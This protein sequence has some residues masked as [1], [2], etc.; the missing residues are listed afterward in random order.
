MCR[1]TRRV[2]SSPADAVMS[3]ADDAVTACDG[4]RADRPSVRTAGVANAL[5]SPLEHKSG[6]G[7]LEWD[8]GDATFLGNDGEKALNDAS[9]D[10]CSDPSDAIEEFPCDDDVFDDALLEDLLALEQTGGVDNVHV[11]T[12]ADRR[13]SKVSAGFVDHRVGPNP[14]PDPDPT[15]RLGLAVAPAYTPTL[16]NGHRMHVTPPAAHGQRNLLSYFGSIAGVKKAVSD[17]VSLV[18]G[19]IAG[20]V[21]HALANVSS[22]QS[23]TASKVLESSAAVDTPSLL[24]VDAKK[25]K[26]RR[27]RLKTGASGPQ[28]TPN[29]NPR[30]QCPFYKWIPG[31]P[32]VVDAFRYGRIA[33]ASAYF[34]SH[35]HSDHYG[36]L[37]KGWSHGPIYC[38]APTANLAEASL[39]VKREFLVVLPLD[40]AVVVDGVEVTLVDANHCPGSAMFLF[41]LRDG[42]SYF[43]TGD[44]R[45]DSSMVSHT[46]LA[47]L[48]LTGVFLDTTYCDPRY[49]FP[50]QA[51]C[52]QFAA[53]TAR[54]AVIRN[55]RTLVVVGTYVIGKE[56]VFKAI[57]DAL[58][59]KIYVDERKYRTLAC[60]EWPELTRMLTRD[61]NA[62]RLH[63]VPLWDI[64]T[65]KLREYLARYSPRYN[66]VVAFRPTAGPFRAL[67]RPT[68]TK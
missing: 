68:S 29:P 27:Q 8:C 22:R 53:D 4:G 6:C 40:T 36:G 21:T 58:G 14:T 26:V 49:A 54:A 63:V 15:A 65:K 42:R 25:G 13:S 66:A 38:T 2:F 51:E 52:V 41:R 31:T 12:P 39:G 23:T 43:H 57:A 20:R 10:A 17:T 7:R 28:D 47:G 19:A 55:N 61:E 44:F 18:S 34:L 45:A 64:G 48:R 24:P 30:R 3:D 33:G 37:S 16:G 60:L 11:T 5:S 50:P 46:A 56:R 62:T 9:D 32:F 67:Q 1:R 35:F 59:S